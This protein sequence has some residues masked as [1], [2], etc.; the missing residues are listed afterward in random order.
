MEGDIAVWDATKT[1]R[2]GHVAIVLHKRDD[3]TLAVFEQDGFLQK[4]AEVKVRG[5]ENLLGY[6]RARSV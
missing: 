4:G 1:N 6:L 3:G 2:Y 5:T